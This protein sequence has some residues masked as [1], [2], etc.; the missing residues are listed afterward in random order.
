MKNLNRVLPVTIAFMIIVSCSKES[1][2][3]LEL[4]V[5]SKYNAVED[6]LTAN[7]VK[8]QSF[9]FEGSTGGVFTAEQGTEIFIPAY[10]FATESGFPIAGNV[11][12][13][14]KEIY[15]KS[16]MVLSAKPTI[17]WDGRP[18]KSEGEFFLRATYNGDAVQIAPGASIVVVPNTFGL[19]SDTN[20]EAFT[21]Q[22][23]PFSWSPATG[24]SVVDSVFNRLFIGQLLNPKDSGT[25]YNCDD[26]SLFDAYQQTT[27]ALHQNDATYLYDTQVFLV[28]D[29]INTVLQV[30]N[31]GN[32]FKFDFA[33]VGL[34]CMA[35]A[36]GVKE[37]ILY[38]S[39]VPITIAPNQTI[40][41]T[42]SPVS[43]EMLKGQLRL[44]D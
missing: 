30:D 8:S 32:D 22:M 35:V 38:S 2:N 11:T 14:F 6:F 23:N 31:T 20:M 21:A 24:A 17:Q 15:K 37:G 3:P 44:L 41:F 10:S 28:F 33:P 1:N 26:G 4:P 34:N 19:P 40:A 43:E 18:L 13:E 9:T 25:W 27:L 29:D 42:M 5:T 39:I 7:E 36:L 12:L 16:D